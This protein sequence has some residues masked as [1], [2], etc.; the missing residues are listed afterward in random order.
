MLFSSGLEHKDEVYSCSQL[1]NGLIPVVPLKQVIVTT[2]ATKKETQPPLSR[3]FTIS[4]KLFSSLPDHTNSPPPPPYNLPKVSIESKARPQG[5]VF[6]PVPHV[7]PEQV[8]VKPRI[9]TQLFTTAKSE[10]PKPQIS[11]KLFSKIVPE[12]TLKLQDTLKISE[13]KNQTDKVFSPVCKPQSAADKI[14]CKPQSTDKIFTPP[15]YQPILDKIFEPISK[16]ESTV[17][18]DFDRPKLHLVPDKLFSAFAKPEKTSSPVSVI[19]ETRPQPA[20][21]KIFAPRT[22]EMLNGFLTYSDD[23][24]GLTSKYFNLKYSYLKT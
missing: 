11:T 8:K 16:I 7:P 4:A 6:C 17:D 15:R 21:S 22:K 18:K 14:F 1:E 10:L 23:E 24:S 13:S 19:Q 20:T 2:V 3:P 9:V 12:T 5:T